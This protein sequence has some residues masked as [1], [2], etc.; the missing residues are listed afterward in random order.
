MD[1]DLN[2]LTQGQLPLEDTSLQ[3]AAAEAFTRGELEF[4]YRGERHV[5]TGGY[6]ADGAPIGFVIENR[7]S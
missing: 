4:M 7:G 1:Q 3:A 6:D 2:D 5:I